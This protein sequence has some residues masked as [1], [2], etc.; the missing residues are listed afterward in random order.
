MRK[1]FTFL[2]A[3]LLSVSMF[4]VEATVIFQANNNTKEVTV[5]LPH[6]FWCDYMDEDGEL[7]IIIR[8]L[9]EAPFSGF[10][11]DEI[12]PESSGNA[13]VTAGKYN[14][15]HFINVDAP[16]EGTATVSGTYYKWISDED[17]EPFSYNLT[18]STRIEPASYTLQLVVNDDE[19]GSIGIINLPSIDITLNEDGT[20]T[21]PEGTELMIQA[22]P[23]EGYAFSGWR[24]GNIGELNCYYCGTAMNTMDNPMTFY[25]HED[26]AIMASF[27]IV[28]KFEIYYED[29]WLNAEPV[30][31]EGQYF[32]F[33][34]SK[35][36]YDNRVSSYER[37]DM[38]SFVDGMIRNIIEY[39]AESSFVFSG[40]QK[41]NPNELYTA[42][43]EEDLSV[44]TD[45]LAFIFQYADHV[46]TSDAEY[47][48]LTFAGEPEA[49][50]VEHVALDVKKAK[51]MVI[52]GQ[53]YIVRE[54][55]LFNVAGAQ[56]R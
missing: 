24:E 36:L 49:G 55:K 56:V 44:N 54:G 17:N 4:A 41:L 3:A 51:K 52:D 2:F 43:N 7:D 31:A 32:V 34:E 30:D 26:K 9:Y 47:I 11:S 50:A 40:N 15:D 22:T 27:E 12:A 18:I 37:K 48:V 6:K 39:G 8:E 1:L 14:D 35:E 53:L 16:F 19:M 42:I 38:N 46:R 25:M 33:I 10:C 20:Y 29:K 23:N 21:V 28:P 5:N 45:Y 13:A